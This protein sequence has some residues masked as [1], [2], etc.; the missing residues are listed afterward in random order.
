MIYHAEVTET[1]REFYTVEA[2]SADEA[3]KMMHEGLG[4]H[5]PADDD[6]QLTMSIWHEPDTDDE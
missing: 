2:A 3:A 4:E 1:T 5:H 6:V